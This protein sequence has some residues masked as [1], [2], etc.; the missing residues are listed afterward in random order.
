MQNGLPEQLYPT[1]LKAFNEQSFRP[2][3]LFIVAASFKDGLT[4]SHASEEKPEDAWSAVAKKWSG[5]VIC[6][7]FVTSSRRVTWADCLNEIGANGINHFPHGIAFD[8]D[9]KIALTEQELNEFLKPNDAAQNPYEVP[10]EADSGHDWLFALDEETLSELLEKQ[11]TLEKSYNILDATELQEYCRRRFGCDFPNLAATDEVEI[12]DTTK[13][14]FQ[15]GM[16]EPE[17]KIPPLR[18]GVLKSPSNLG[19]TT[20]TLMAYMANKFNIELYFFTPKDINRENETVNATLIEG[21]KRIKKIIPLPKIIYDL[22]GYFYRKEIKAMFR[23]LKNQ[24]YFFQYGWGAS[25]EKMYDILSADERFKKFLI[26][27]HTVK[28]FDHFMALFKQYHN[29]VVIKPFN[30]SLGKG[31]IR[32]TFD[33]EKYI[34]NVDKEKI[35]FNTVD[36]LKNFYEKNFTPVK[37][38]LQP[39]IVSR[40]KYGNPF[41][42]R[43]HVRR[44]AEGKFKFFP[45]PRLGRAY[46]GILSNISAGGYTMPI[47]KFLKAEFGDDWKNVYDKMINLSSLLSEFVQA[48]FNRRIF[49]IGIDI[50][51]VRREDSYELKLFEVNTYN[52]G[53]V[54]IPIEAAF[55]TLEY[56]QY[57]GKNLDKE[58]I[59]P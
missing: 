30:G 48:S 32:V 41:D 10:A 54:G 22:V 25:K 53:I 4:I 7:E 44:G 23:S 14:L 57:L 27:T 6:I 16:S 40:T 55:V 11:D 51:I 28:D 2:C 13:I 38:V 46:D 52:P 59:K 1:F 36:E 12:F 37:Q 3:H 31:V 29:D 49:S 5:G 26:D 56:L 43:I 58:V 19:Y 33:G 50:G 15:E 21:N 24:P 34:I 20:T 42:I 17:I 8:K 35:F 39:Y 18:V 47:V 45:Y 9:W